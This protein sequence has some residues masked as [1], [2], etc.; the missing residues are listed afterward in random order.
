MK[1]IYFLGGLFHGD[2]NV[3]SVS[4]NSKY[5]TIVVDEEVRRGTG[6]GDAFCAAGRGSGSAFAAPRGCSAV[7]N[8]LSSAS[9]HHLGTRMSNVYS[10]PGSNPP[11]S[12]S[13]NNSSSPIP[14]GVLPAGPEGPS[15]CIINLFVDGCGI[16]VRP[17]RLPRCSF[18][19]FVES[20][21]LKLGVA[22]SLDWIETSLGAWSC[23]V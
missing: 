7:D 10:A 18:S 11:C 3:V 9:S 19:S 20:L 22:I 2:M 23:F 17:G 4:D 21:S 6:I 8:L 12:V 5:R 1:S 14:M 15:S 16:I 13:A